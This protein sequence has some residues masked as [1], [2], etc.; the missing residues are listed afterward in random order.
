[1]KIW[2]EGYGW[3]CH[4]GRLDGSGGD[5]RGD[6]LMEFRHGDGYMFAINEGNGRGCGYGCAISGRGWQGHHPST[7][8]TPSVL[9]V[10]V[11]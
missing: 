3:G 7:H 2:R 9:L 1:M 8:F 4:F 5:G 6:C 11:T 10:E